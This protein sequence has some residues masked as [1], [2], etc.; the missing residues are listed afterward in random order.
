MLFRKVITFFINQINTRLSIYIFKNQNLLSYN[1]FSIFYKLNICNKNFKKKIFNDSFGKLGTLKNELIHQINK[2][3]ELQRTNMGQKFSRYEINENIKLIIKKII[4]QELFKYLL[5][6]ENYYNSRVSLAWAGISRNYPIKDHS[7]EAYSNYYHNDAYTYN[8]FKIFINL[9][10]VTLS[11]GPM[12]LVKKNKSKDFIKFHRYKSRNDY[13][14]KLKTPDDYVYINT[15][16]QGDIFFCNTT[17]L[18]HKAGEPTEGYFRDM[19]FLNFVTTPNHLRQSNF[20][21]LEEQGYNLFDYNA[22]VPKIFAKPTGLKKLTNLY[23]SFK[24][25]KIN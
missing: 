10:D 9:H 1:I 18:I 4:N 2:D 5:D 15:G 8:L 13:L 22:L 16:N 11:N 6:F 3:L 23:K 19:L 12:H 25:N 17:E 20:L 7:K 21:Y 24:N 14:K